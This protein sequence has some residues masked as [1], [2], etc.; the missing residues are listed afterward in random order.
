MNL[1][2][3]TL[4][5]ATMIFHQAMFVSSFSSSINRA[6]LSSTNAMNQSMHKRITSLVT[7]SISSSSVLQSRDSFLAVDRSLKRKFSNV[8]LSSTEKD[9]DTAIG[10]TT[11]MSESDNPYANKN[12]I[13]D[14]VFSALSKCG[15]IKVTCATARNLVNELMLMHT[16]A[17]VPADAI[18]RATTCGLLLSNGMAQDHVVQ[19]TINGDGPL[20]GICT[21]TTGRGECRGYVGVPGLQGF[22]LEDAVGKGTVQVVKNHPDWPNPYNGITAIIAG[23]VDQ[24]IGIYLA[25][26]EQRSCALAAATTINGI[27]CTSAGGYLVEQ[28]PGCDKE[29]IAK[30]EQN[31]KTLVEKDGGD[32]LPSNLLLNGYTP[33]DIAEIILDGL[34]MQPLQQITPSFFCGCSDERLIR[35]LRLLPK[36][37]VDDLIEK[38][39][40][41]EARCE[42]CGTVYRLGPD[43]VR[44]RMA[45]AV[46]DPSRVDP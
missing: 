16:M 3:Q 26:S 42:F 29:S 19:I 9:V 44:E 8:I 6:F 14:Q 24:D 32:R 30:V 37:D 41:I 27:L 4:S 36:E 11:N 28:L 7:R 18:S 23:D 45:S 5:V 43:E 35:S 34:D 20:R 39:E 2:L 12:N 21:T 15:G 22:T 1:K 25:E 13:D 46:G 40:Q 31:L 38:Q 17:E 10:E 33:F